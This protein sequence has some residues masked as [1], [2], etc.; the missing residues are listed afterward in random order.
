LLWSKIQAKSSTTLERDRS[1]Q[2]MQLIKGWVLRGSTFLGA[3]CC[4]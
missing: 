2:I 3:T 4:F 1:S